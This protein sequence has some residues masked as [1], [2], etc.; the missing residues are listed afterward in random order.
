MP[1][2]LKRFDPNE[3]YTGSPQCEWPYQ[4]NDGTCDFILQDNKACNFDVEDCADSDLCWDFKQSLTCDEATELGPF[5]PQCAIDSA[6]I[7][8]SLT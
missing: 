7:C 4:I 3:I 8:N 5:Y 6:T 2:T 1:P